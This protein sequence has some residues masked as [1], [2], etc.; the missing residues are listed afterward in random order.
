MICK[1]ERTT[2]SRPR[3]RRIPLVDER[4]AERAW[5]LDREIVLSRVFD[6]PRER[7]FPA[8]FH[9][10]VT[11]DEQSNKKTIVTMRQ[12]HPTKEPRAVGIGFGAVELGYQTLDKLAEHLRSQR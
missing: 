5:A 2:N 10:T 6:A 1:H 9:V 8:R 4:S 12:L 3:K 11:L 7:V